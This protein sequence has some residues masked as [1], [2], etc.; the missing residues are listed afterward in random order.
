MRNCSCIHTISTYWKAKKRTFCFRAEKGVAESS[1]V[2][3]SSQH[4]ILE[5]NVARSVIGRSLT[6]VGRDDQDT[7]KY[8]CQPKNLSGRWRGCQ[9]SFDKKE[10]VKLSP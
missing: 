2:W 4:T 10:I 7:S 8:R 6:L 1:A 5:K 9:S 3:V